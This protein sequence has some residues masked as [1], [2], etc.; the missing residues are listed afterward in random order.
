MNTTTIIAAGGDVMPPA[1]QLDVFEFDGVEVRTVTDPDGQTLFVAADIARALGYRMASDMTRRLDDDERGTRSVRTPGGDQTMI[2]ITESG[3]YAAV[4]GS[5]VE[6]ATRFRRWVTGEVL[7]AIRRHGGY[8]TPQAAEAA[9]SDPDFIIRLATSLKEERAA[10]AAAEQRATALAA[11]VEA[12]APH[13]RL[14]RAVSESEGDVLVKAVADALTQE[15]IPCSQVQLFRWLR[16]HGW[17]CRSQGDMWN[18]PTKWALDKGYVRAVE[19][20]VNT[21]SGSRLRWVPRVTGLGQQVLV[22]GFTTGRF[23]LNEEK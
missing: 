22:D 13:T 11:R 12:D 1:G 4:L 15:G 10:R 9:L 3:V 8:L 5:R 19:H 23:D 14:G 21:R 16:A 7:P 20:V 18:R 6:G 17:L 2:V